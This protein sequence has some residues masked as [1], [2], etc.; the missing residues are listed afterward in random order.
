MFPDA[1][2]WNLPIMFSD[3]A[4]IVLQLHK[5]RGSKCTAYK[6]EAWCL[7]KEEVKEMVENIWKANTQGSPLYKIQ[8][9]VFQCRQ[10]LKHWCLDVKHRQ[11]SWNW[12]VIREQFET[13]QNHEDRDLLSS[14]SEIT[15]RKHLEE[16]ATKKWWYWRQRA[17]SKW[18]EYGD[19]STAFF[20]KSVK[21]RTVIMEIRALQSSS[22]AWI[23]NASKTGLS[24]PF[25]EGE[26]K[27]AVFTPKPL[28]L[29][30]PGGAP[31][32]FF[33]ENWNTIRSDIVKAVQ[34]FFR[35]ENLLRE[36]N[37]TFITLI[38]KKKQ[39]SRMD[40][41]RPISLCNS[42]YKIISKCLVNRL[43][44]ILPETIGEFQ[45]TFVIG[46]SMVDNCYIAHELLSK[47][48]ARRKGGFFEAML[49][50]DLSKAYGR[51]Y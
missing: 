32:M 29:P 20:F 47:V 10:G 26:I 9:K 30:G 24:K 36:C 51:V 34:H 39:P 40:D 37:K 49:K 33:Q 27:E 15:A 2:V 11:N 48:K 13:H 3:H 12:Q 17:K 1:L 41:F 42:M 8:K 16:E 23:T 7:K 45:N 6:M 19:Q 5:T 25:T 21:Q 43:K 38:P 35:T 4:P 28:K 46:R 44:K 31:P 14:P 50:I 18:D 22:G